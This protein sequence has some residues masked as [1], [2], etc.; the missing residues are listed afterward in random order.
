MEPF[1]II[2]SRKAKGPTKS[3]VIYLCPMCKKGDDKSTKE[4]V[5]WVACDTCKHVV[6]FKLHF[7]FSRRT[8]M[9]MSKMLG[10]T[11][12]ISL[13]YINIII[14]IIIQVCLMYIKAYFYDY[15]T[16]LSMS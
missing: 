6:S 13:A 3:V 15:Y 7:M 5:D 14:M 16:V 4:A 11:V 9:G 10:S 1:P 2:K 8:I 12:T